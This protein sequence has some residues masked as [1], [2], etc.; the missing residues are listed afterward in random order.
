MK[1][2]WLL[3]AGIVLRT[4]VDLKQVAEVMPT[5]RQR[6]KTVRWKNGHKYFYILFRASD[7]RESEIRL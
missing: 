4:A 6:K 3:E 2:A 1:K 7:F 5:C